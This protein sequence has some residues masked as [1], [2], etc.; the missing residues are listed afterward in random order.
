MALTPILY[1]AL[2]AL[3]AQVAWEDRSNEIP[4][5]APPQVVLAR[6]DPQGRYI[7]RLL[8][9]PALRLANDRRFSSQI[10]TRVF[11]KNEISVYDTEGKPVDE[12][13]LK[14]ILK[15]EIVALCSIDGEQVAPL[16]LRLIKKGTLI[17]VVPQWPAFRF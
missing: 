9:P 4:R 8:A 3:L 5:E 2:T 7:L 6:M 13:I 16:Y 1:S 14:S 10:E 15:K 11:E 17:F 12:Q